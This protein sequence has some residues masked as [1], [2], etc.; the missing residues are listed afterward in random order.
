MKDKIMRS[1]AI[2]IDDK[3]WASGDEDGKIRI[4]EKRNHKYKLKNILEDGTLSPVCSLAYL[5]NGYIASGRKN[6]EIQIW[7]VRESR[8]ERTL[9]GHLKEVIVLMHMNIYGN[10]NLLS[11]CCDKVVKIW[12]VKTGKCIKEFDEMKKWVTETNINK[13]VVATTIKNQDNKKF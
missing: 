10:E 12:D 8:L 6:G 3:V 5:E 4:Y 7:D 11:G 1:H 2:D 13:T 9:K